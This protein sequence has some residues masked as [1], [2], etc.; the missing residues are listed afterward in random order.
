MD[1]ERRRECRVQRFSCKDCGKSFVLEK[2]FE[3]MKSSPK[4]IPVALDL[5][6]KGCSY[7]KI[8]DHLKQFYG[9]KVTYVAIIKWVRKYTELMKQYVGGLK[10][11]VS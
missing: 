10:P 11:N 4:I 7:R 3:R 8:V 5:F 1:L 9:V 6:F 2:A